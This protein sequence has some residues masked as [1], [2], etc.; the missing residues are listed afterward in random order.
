MAYKKLNEEELKSLQNS[1]R[2]YFENRD[3]F[4]KLITLVKKYFTN[5]H[6]ILISLDSE[7]ND[8]GYDNKVSGVYVYNSKD[9]EV[10]L[11]R[12]NREKFTKE[13]QNFSY[14]FESES[15]EYLEDI[16]LHVGNSL[17]E[18]YVKE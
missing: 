2:A 9:E 16:V 5:P 12:S 10:P 14:N 17:P 11:T 18:V 15:S 6:T 8:Q 4:D 1:L 7:Y 13:L 3:E